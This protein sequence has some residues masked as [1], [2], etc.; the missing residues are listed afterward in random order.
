MNLPSKST[1]QCGA[2]KKD[3]DSRG[4]LLRLVPEAKVENHSRKDSSL[5]SA[6]EKSQSGDTRKIFRSSDS[7]TEAAKA[8][9]EKAE[10]SRDRL[11]L[12]SSLAPLGKCVLC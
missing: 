3:S 11:P 2:A 12:V 9:D 10:P 8:N 1:R 5:E 4:S 7:G 6:E